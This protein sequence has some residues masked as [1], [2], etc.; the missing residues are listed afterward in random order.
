MRCFM[1]S[2]LSGNYCFIYQGE[3]VPV[4]EE[5]EEKAAGGVLGKGVE[6]GKGNDRAGGGGE[7]NPGIAG[8]GINVVAE[9]GWEGEMVAAEKG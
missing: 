2:R 1:D 6:G 8:K 4:G 9:A 7:V 3:E 5:E